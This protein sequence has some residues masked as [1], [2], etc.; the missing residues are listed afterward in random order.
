MSL[1]FLAFEP[2]NKL[3]GWRGFEWKTA[4]LSRKAVQDEVKCDGQTDECTLIGRRV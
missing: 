1:V 3:N 4:T 2:L